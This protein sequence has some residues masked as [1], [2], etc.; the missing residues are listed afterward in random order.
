MAHCRSGSDEDKYETSESSLED[1]GQSKG[2]RASP[3][4]DATSHGK[5]KKEVFL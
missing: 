2:A 1:E 3:N 4:N 5:T